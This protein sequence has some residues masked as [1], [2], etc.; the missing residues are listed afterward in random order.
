MHRLKNSKK[1]SGDTI[2]NLCGGGASIYVLWFYLGSFFEPE[3]YDHAD[4]IV[5]T[6]E[7]EFSRKCYNIVPKD[8]CEVMEDC[9]NIQLSIMYVALGIAGL[10]CLCS[11]CAVAKASQRAPDN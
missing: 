3:C 2:N 5:L 1:S 9:W 7:C 11:C 4:E 10:F 8:E 6:T